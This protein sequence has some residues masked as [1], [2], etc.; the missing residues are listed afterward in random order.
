MGDSNSIIDLGKLAEPAKV[1]IEKISDAIGGIA[2]PWQMRRVAEAQAEADEIGAIAAIEITRLQQRALRRML[3]E[4]EQECGA[5]SD[6]ASTRWTC[7]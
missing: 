1:L 4:V 6:S 2:R 3:M 7:A 5:H